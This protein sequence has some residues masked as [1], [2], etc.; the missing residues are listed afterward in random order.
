MCGSG[1][2]WEVNLYESICFAAEA[3]EG[4]VQL[5]KLEA[6]EEIAGQMAKSRNVSYLPPNQSVLLSLPAQ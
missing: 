4:L 2:N 6:A 5:R 1:Q 3:G